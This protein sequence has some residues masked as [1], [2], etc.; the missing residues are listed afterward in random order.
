MAVDDVMSYIKI[1]EAEILDF[2]VDAI[3]YCEITDIKDGGK[4]IEF[5]LNGEGLAEHTLNKLKRNIASVA[6]MSLGIPDLKFNEYICEV[7]TDK[8]NM[9]KSYKLICDISVMANG[10]DNP[11]TEVISITVNSYDDV[12]I[13]FPSDLSSY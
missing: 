7:L 3:T 9:M 4:K 1:D 8:N 2:P 11:L 6:Y 12:K 5:V 13:N 10:K